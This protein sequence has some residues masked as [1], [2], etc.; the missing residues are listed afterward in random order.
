MIFRVLLRKAID[1]DWNYAAL[2]SFPIR[3]QWVAVKTIN[4]HRLFSV[5]SFSNSF[6]PPHPEL[7]RIMGVWRE[8]QGAKVPQ[9]ILKFDIF[10]S[11][12]YKRLFFTFEREKWNFTTFTLPLWKNF[13]DYLCKIHY[14]LP[15]GK[16]SSYSRL[17]IQFN[18]AYRLTMVLFTD[19]DSIAL[20]PG[21][22][23]ILYATHQMKCLPSIA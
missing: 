22:S 3:R 23:V 11:H 9:W 12:F 18:V 13:F 8:G 6:F 19:V 4:R 14:C 5:L 17:V 21:H 20:M 2:I 7:Y 16:S 15:P 1:K 10:L